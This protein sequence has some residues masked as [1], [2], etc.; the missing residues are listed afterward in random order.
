MADSG[1]I[2]H[3]GSTT[4]GAPTEVD[5]QLLNGAAAS[6]DRGNEWTHTIVD[7]STDAAN[8]VSGG[9]PAV[10]GGIYVDTVLS[11]HACPILNNATTVFSLVAS[12]AAG[13]QITWCE[14][15]IFSTS[16]VVNSN[17]AATGTIV[18]KWRLYTAP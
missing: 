8:A 14:G 16:L 7:L 11:A 4:A 17:D 10:L 2:K 15:M 13:S 6:I 1:F 18:V 9:L 3:K 5:Q 12:L